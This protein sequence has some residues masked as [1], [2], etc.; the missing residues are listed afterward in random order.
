MILLQLVAFTV[1][2]FVVTCGFGYA[3]FL[4]TEARRPNPAA[5]YL[6]EARRLMAVARADKAQGYPH[7]SRAAVQ[8]ALSYRRA[9]HASR[10]YA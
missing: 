1:F 9:A 10:Y 4:I 5:E 7:A 2:V 6:A 8:A 3:V